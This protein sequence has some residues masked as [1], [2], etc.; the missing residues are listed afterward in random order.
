MN[1]KS[2]RTI[3]AVNLF[4]LLVLAV[5]SIDFVMVATNQKTN[6]AAKAQLQ[7]TLAQKV[8]QNLRFDQ[9]GR[10]ALSP[11][12]PRQTAFL[13]QSGQIRANLVLAT[14][15]TLLS[16]SEELNEEWRRL[17]GRYADQASRTGQSLTGFKDRTW[18]VFLLRP[19]Y[20]VT[21]SPVFLNGDMVALVS[22]AFNLEHFYAGQ[23]RHQGI[24][25]TYALI[26]IIILTALGLFFLNR[27]A[28]R[29]IQRLARRAEEYQ[30]DNDFDF[31]QYRERNEFQQLSGAL[32]RMTQRIS[33]DKEKLQ[34][35]LNHLE[36]ANQEIRDRQNELI[37][38]E[39]MASVGRLS[40]GLAHE[41][42][43]PLGIVLGYLE[44]LEQQELSAEEKND[45]LSRCRDEINRINVIIRELLD[46][47]RSSAEAAR[48]PVAV[49]D[50]IAEA[51]S[52][53]K[54]QPLT[55][56]VRL[57]CSL[58]AESDTV[59]AVSD[60]LRQVLINLVL[61]AV[62]A[63]N[64]TLPPGRGII[65][66]QTRTETAAGSDQY[67]YLVITIAD[68]GAG[69]AENDIDNIFD[70][71]FT[72]KDPGQGTGLGLSVSYMIIEASGGDIRVSS[73]VN[74]GTTFTV[75]LPL[76]NPDIS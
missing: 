33:N 7:R 52:M 25:L 35:S 74:Q 58:E 59:I 16:A 50:I 17:L 43:N 70:P 18:G 41:I 73:R 66:I 55:R 68:N 36:N 29:P 13:L 11:S 38:A 71:F 10:P 63:V 6:L 48:E 75:R 37:K 64:L 65:D 24:I 2:L 26:N 45:Y 4:I 32:N 61:N 51:V 27:T 72:T 34:K 22:T 47:A 1:I 56:Q 54:V 14:D 5:L 8:R 53:L 20:L 21:A 57:E 39:K 31:Y 3:I 67:Q 23:R 69:I 49:H 76:A 46:F 9:A 44:M 60:R 19:R 28:V 62:D 42:G 40:A 30:D 15:G 12:W